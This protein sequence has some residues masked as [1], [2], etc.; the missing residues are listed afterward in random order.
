MNC[1][2]VP[3]LQKTLIWQFVNHMTI[4]SNV[5]WSTFAQQ[6]LFYSFPF[7]FTGNSGRVIWLN[8]QWLEVWETQSW[9]LLHIGDKMYQYVFW[10]WL[11]SCSPA[12][13]TGRSGSSSPCFPRTAPSLL[14]LGGWDVLIVIYGCNMHVGC[15]SGDYSNNWVSWWQRRG[16]YVDNCALETTLGR[17]C[18]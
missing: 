14:Y 18:W 9:V 6:S 4:T 5:S 10:C 12:G 3:T 1:Q 11:W 8:A 15:S 17:G 16:V 7:L 2:S 13:S